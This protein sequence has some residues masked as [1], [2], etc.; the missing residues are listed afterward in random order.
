MTV[1]NYS[2][3]AESYFTRARVD[4]LPFIPQGGVDR[5]LEVGCGNGATLS[6]LKEYGLA[7]EVVGI[8][9]MASVAA[10]ADANIDQMQVGD[11]VALVQQLPSDHFDVVLCLDVLEHMVDP[12]SFVESLERVI[13]PGGCLIASIP[14]VRTLPVI[15]KLL[16]GGKFVYAQ[17][18]IMD[19]THLRFFTRRSALALMQTAQLQLSAWKPSPM[20]PWSKSSIFNV[21]SLGLLRDLVTEQFLVKSTKKQ[22]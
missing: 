13:K 20:A 18:G 6:Y 14:N 4:I 3:K 12:W 21:I 10:Q 2:H 8:E 11:A 19:R 15:C 9:L 16:F 17:Q 5:V 7:Q 1:Q 22:G